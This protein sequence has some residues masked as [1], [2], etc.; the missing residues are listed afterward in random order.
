MPAVQAWVCHGE[1]HRF[2]QHLTEALGEEKQNK[3]MKGR[4]GVE[5][6]NIAEDEKDVLHS[7]NHNFWNKGNVFFTL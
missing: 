4:R 3:G 5:K 2:T 1:D 6:G 7:K